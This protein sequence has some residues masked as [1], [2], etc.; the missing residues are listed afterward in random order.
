MHIV[1][2]GPFKKFCSFKK[3]KLLV[4]FRILKMVGG[5]RKKMQSYFK[6]EWL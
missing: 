1:N 2:C 5:R 3:K 4:G 6:I